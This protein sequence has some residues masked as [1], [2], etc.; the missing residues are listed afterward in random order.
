MKKI[1]VAIS[2]LLLALLC[3]CAPRER[4][5]VILSTNDMHSRIGN[6]PRLATAVAACRDTVATL[7]VDAG[8]RWTGGVAVDRAPG[9]RPVLELMNRLGYDVATLGNHEFDVGQQT[10][11]EA[12]GYADFPIICANMEPVASP[13]APL[14]PYLILEREGVRLAFVAAVTN[15]GY[16]NH[17]DGHDAVFEGLRFTDAVEELAGYGLLLRDSCQVLVALTH[18]GSGYDRILAE[19][20]PEYDLIIGGHSHERIDERIG[21]VLITQT[22]RNLAAVG[23]TTVRMCGDRIRSIDF[24]IVPLDGYAPD[25]LYSEWVAAYEEAP[26]LRAKAGELTAAADKAGVANLFLDA[27]RRKTGAEVVFYHYGGLRRDSLAAGVVTR[28]DVYD[29]DPFVS[30]V[31][32]LRMTPEQMARMIRTKYN[33]TINRG[34][35]HRIDLFSTEPYVIRTDGYDAEEVLFPRLQPGREYRVAMGD[36]VFANYR[37]IDCSAGETT[38]WEVPDVLMEYVANGGRPLAPD[39]TLRQ[40]VEK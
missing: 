23:A 37:D 40:R 15:Y 36:Y 2:L 1:H 8:D 22:G 20:A 33:D 38:G 7:L 16:N 13:I 19:R 4:T 14:R 10:L 12:I 30:H 21:D 11:A 32:T 3:G 29:L 5:I 35:S 27:I 34:E 17:P 26:E 9:R 18:L 31:S 28:G 25:P 39:N 6:F 24:R